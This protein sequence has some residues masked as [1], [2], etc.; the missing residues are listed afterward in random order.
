MKVAPLGEE[1]ATNPTADERRSWCQPK[2]MAISEHS[3]LCPTML[4]T[5]WGWEGENIFG[6]TA[7]AKMEHGKRFTHQCLHHRVERR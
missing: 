7:R 5:K 2:G 3:L 6:Q 1:G 4:G